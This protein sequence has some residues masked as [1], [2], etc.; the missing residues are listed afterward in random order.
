MLFSLSESAKLLGIKANDFYNYLV[1][2]GFCYFRNY[3]DE[4]ISYAKYSGIGKYFVLRKAG[5]HK[6][7]KLTEIGLRYFAKQV[8]II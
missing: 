6:K 1:D 8:F 2:N 4:P 7:C 3:S 5:R